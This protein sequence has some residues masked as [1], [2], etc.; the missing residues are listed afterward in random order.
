MKTRAWE[1]WED[2]IVRVFYPLGGAKATRAMLLE[3]GSDR[4]AAAI[5]QRALFLNVPYR[6]AGATARRSNRPPRT[7]YERQLALARLAESADAMGGMTLDHY[8][9]EK[10]R[11]L[12]G[13]Q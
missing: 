11:I 2:E 13:E 4:S 6:A 3:R 1:E 10:A 9:A 7:R 12:Q 8:E 5:G